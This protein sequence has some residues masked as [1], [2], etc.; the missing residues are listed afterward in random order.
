MRKGIILMTALPPTL[1]HAYL[2]DWALAYAQSAGIGLVEVLVC[3]TDREPFP[4]SARLS[5]LQEHFA[6]RGPERVLFRTLHGDVPQYPEEHPDF[7]NAWRDYVRERTSNSEGD[8]LFASEEYGKP[9]AEALKCEFVPCNTYREVVNISATSIRARPLENFAYILPEAQ[10][11]FRRTVTMFGAESTGKTT[12]AR[13]MAKEMGGFYAPEWA[14]EY[15]ELCG[16]E[17]TDERMERI[18]NGQLA[19]EATVGAMTGK[20]FIFRDTDLLSTIGYYRIYKGREPGF[21]REMFLTSKADLYVLMSSGIPFERDVLR[22]GGDKRESSDAFWQ[23]LLDEFECQSFVVTE[24][25]REWQA[26]AVSA[27][28]RSQFFAHPLWKYDRHG[29]RVGKEIP[30]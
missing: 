9:L 30:A 26:A 20:P 5:A 2:I 11:H 21:V 18:A 14:R 6:S 24:T 22:Y 10:K 7:W 28:C 23:A 1:G 3:S 27:A 29:A 25:D 15:L 12:M 8:V 17:V 16:F 19:T 4:G 13:R